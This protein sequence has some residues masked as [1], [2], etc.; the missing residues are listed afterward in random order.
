MMKHVRKLF[1]LEKPGISR[2]DSLRGVPFVLP[3]IMTEMNTKGERVLVVPRGKEGKF[4]GHFPIPPARIILDELGSAVIDL[5]DGKRSVGAVAT[6]FSEKFGVQSREGEAGVVSFL[7]MLMTRGVL[8][9]S[10]PER[11]APKR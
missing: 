2:S 8:A 4:M 11:C 6:L 9:I 5:I 1:G 7:N 3:H 10:F